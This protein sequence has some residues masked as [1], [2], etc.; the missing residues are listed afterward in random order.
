MYLGSKVPPVRR[1]GNL[2][3]ICEP[4]VLDSV[5]TLTSHNLIDLYGL[6]RG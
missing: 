3:A 1:A 5:G 2:A 6:L 4:I